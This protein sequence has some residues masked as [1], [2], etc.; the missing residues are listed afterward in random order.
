MCSC[1][2]NN[3]NNCICYLL[4]KIEEIEATFLNGGGCECD[5]QPTALSFDNETDILSSTYADGSVR[6]TPIDFIFRGTYQELKEI[7]DEDG[8][9]IGKKYILTDYQTEYYIN[10]SNSAPIIREYEVTQITSGF[11]QFSPPLSD[12][13]QGDSVEVIGLPNGYG[14]AIQI[15][16]ITTVSAYFSDGFFIE[17][18]NGMHNTLGFEFRYVLDRFDTQ[19]ALNNATILDSNNKPVLKPLGVINTEV[20]DGT[21]YMSMTGSEN[22]G[23]PVEEISL[24]AISESEFSLQAESLTFLGDTL[25]YDFNNSDIEN[26]DGVVIGSRKGFILRRVNEDLNI[27][28]NKDWRVQRYRRFK[29]EDTDEWN[30]YILE[31]D[32]DNSLYIMGGTNAFSLS[33]ETLTEN[34]KFILRNIENRDF[35]Q[36]FTKLGLESNVFLT[37]QATAPEIEYG[38]RYETEDQDEFRLDLVASDVTLAKDFNI[39]QLDGNYEPV[40]T[41]FSLKANFLNN[42]VFLNYNF[43]YGDSGGLNVDIKDGIL[44]STFMTLPSLVSNSYKE[45]VSL[46]NITAIDSLSLVNTGQINN[47]HVLS[48]VQLSNAGIVNYLTL[49]G[50]PTSA[51]AFGVTFMSVKVDDSS[52]LQSVILGGKRLDTIR[53][54]N[55]IATKVLIGFNRGQYLSFSNSIMYLTAMVGS[56]DALTNNFRINTGTVANPKKAL[57]GYFYDNFTGVSGRY[58]FN[59][60]LGDLLYET[61]DGNNMNQASITVY[62]TSQ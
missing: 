1:K 48:T 47:L 12:L 50:K 16:D 54:E 55:T 30:D 41:I 52:Y 46:K 38:F 17:F 49:G 10:S 14:G 32:G 25:E 33:T 57:F 27:D 23:V 37:G 62:S 42:T 19:V 61:Y 45:A 8:L 31:N 53:F 21:A 28:L 35:Y 6:E 39:I 59:N 40:D 22:L 26:E 29:I 2:K 3:K 44:N 60:N 15:G 13:Q 36:D 9:K 56:G 20:H 5:L 24:T 58:I 34:H 18:A 51:T 7:K 4:N 43:Q 11:A